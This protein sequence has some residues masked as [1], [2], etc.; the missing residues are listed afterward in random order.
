LPH[1]Q[2]ISLKV[3]VPNDVVA[4]GVA[5]VGIE[6]RTVGAQILKVYVDGVSW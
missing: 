1:G 4:P 6:W 5:E 2:W 3:K